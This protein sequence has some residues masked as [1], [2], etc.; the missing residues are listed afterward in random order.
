MAASAGPRNR[1]AHRT[2]PPPPNQSPEAVRSPASQAEA[3]SADDGSAAA[4]ERSRLE[5]LR[6]FEVLDT[7]PEEAFDRITR[8]AA[9]LLDM[10]IALVSLVD[11]RRQWFKSR[12]GLQVEQTPRE[13]SFCTHAIQRDEPLIVEDAHE[14]VLF[15]DS[16][17]VCGFPHIRFYAGVPLDCG[18]GL[19]VGTLC[20]ID[21]KPRKLSADQVRALQDLAATASDALESR[22]AARR[23]REA[24]ALLQDAVEALPDGFV[25]FDENDRLLLSNRR[26]REI[27]AASDAAITPGRSFEEILRHGLAMGQYPAAAGREEAWLAERLAAHAAPESSLEQEL[28][29]DRWLRIEERRTRTGGLVGFRMDIT[30]LKR[31]QR[32][33]EALAGDLE[34]QLARAEQAN[35]AKTQFLASVSHELRTPLNA[36]IGFADIF[37]DE[38]FGPLGNAKYREFAGDIRASAAHLL[39]LVNDIL[40]MA[41][42]AAGKFALFPEELDMAAAL[43][44][45][46]KTATL[47]AERKGLA[48]RIVCDPED[49][50]VRAD[51][52]ALRQILF[53]LTANATKFTDPGGRITVAAY[54]ADDTQV[55]LEI[56]DT[57]RG[58]PADLLPELGQPFQR[59]GDVMTSDAGGSGLGLSICK[60]L[61]AAMGG[62]LSIASRLGEGTTVTVTLPRG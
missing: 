51:P 27:Y 57:G 5:R 59:V 46:T 47:E 21:H 11:E 8:I 20:V 40:D 43:E 34:V 23:A 26:Y 29:G 58:I 25:V 16:P 48:L 15:A 32:K 41:K 1:P 10:P 28:P 44:D 42:L 30:E 33:L 49:L 35:R 12:V 39:S 36:V 37:K 9:H 17:L 7:A 13:I 19:K 53:N 24:E 52:R 50:V 61:A 62:G 60:G 54:P 55:K 4:A 3:N 56:T 18:D 22:L 38:M 45:I 2:A 31:Q 14:A 6:S